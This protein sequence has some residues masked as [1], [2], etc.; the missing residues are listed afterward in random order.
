[1]GRPA[2]RQGAADPGWRLRAD[3]ARLG[4][5]PAPL[6]RLRGHFR[7]QAL[8]SGASAPQLHG[9]AARALPAMRQSAHRESVT[10]TVDVDPL[11]MM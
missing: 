5:A 3:D 10:L 8:L 9:L 7:W 6:A 11:T 2:A 4:P 1:M